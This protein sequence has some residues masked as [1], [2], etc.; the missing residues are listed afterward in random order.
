MHVLFINPGLAMGG[1]EQSLFL[2]LQG[3]RAHNVEATVALFGDEPFRN[4]LLAIAVPTVYVRSSG[5][6]RSA[7]RY[8]LSG[9]LLRVAALV[10]AGLPTTVS[11]AA[12]ARQTKA[13]IIHTNGLKAHLLGGLAPR[14]SS[15]CV[16]FCQGTTRARYCAGQHSTCPRLCSPTPTPW[17][18]LY[19][20][21]I[22]A[23]PASSGF[24]TRWTWVV[25]ALA[26]QGAASGRNLGWARMCLW[27]V[28]WVI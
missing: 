15:I 2:L 13:D 3:L 9:A 11:L 21:K 20:P 5:W 8:Q 14:S 25:S 18:L 24:I 10:T 26:C 19:G 17:P 23:A 22:A 6:L 16:I 4:R 1:A 28:A 12:L 7:T 27:S